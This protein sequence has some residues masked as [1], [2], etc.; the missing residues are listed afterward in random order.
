MKLFI[1]ILVCIC[2][3]IGTKAQNINS[4]PVILYGVFPAD[5][6]TTAPF[7]SWFNKNYG[8][9]MPDSISL[10]ALKKQS[11]KDIC[12]QVFLGTWCGDSKR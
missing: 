1:S 12:I 2:A 11:L 4:K 7:N 10:V 9:Y 8:E 5:S 3:S 6:L